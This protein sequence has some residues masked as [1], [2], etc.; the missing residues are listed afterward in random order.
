MR[1]ILA[2]VLFGISTWN[3]VRRAV[4]GKVR[5]SF[6]YREWSIDVQAY[7]AR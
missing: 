3:C 4:V 7:P 2:R 5:K 1:V 6:L